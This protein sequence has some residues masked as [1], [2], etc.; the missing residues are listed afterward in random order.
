MIYAEIV[1]VPAVAEPD[2]QNLSGLESALAQPQQTF[3]GKDLYKTI[4]EKAG[5]LLY[6][7]CM[8]HPFTDGNKRFAF[9]ACRAFLRRHG[10][11]L[12]VDTGKTVDF[13]H[14]VAKGELSAEKVAQ[15]LG[16]RLRDFNP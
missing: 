14:S 11:D 13:M 9:I 8:N 7:L 3:D 10:F 5:A 2:V 16:Q 6:S 15:W 1:E 4:E 12:E